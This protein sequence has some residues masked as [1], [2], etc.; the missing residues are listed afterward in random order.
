MLGII[1]CAVAV[2]AISLLLIAEQGI[3]YNVIAPLL[4]F[5]TLHDPEFEVG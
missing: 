3:L 2:G 5:E 1:V 4:I